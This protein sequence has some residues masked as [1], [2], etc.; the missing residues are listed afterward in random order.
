[1]IQRTKLLFSGIELA[2]MRKSCKG[3]SDNLY[4]KKGFRFLKIYIHKSGLQLFGARCL[5]FLDLGRS[6]L[7]FWVIFQKVSNIYYITSRKHLRHL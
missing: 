1:M 5:V 6:K 7:V 2:E 4:R 3:K